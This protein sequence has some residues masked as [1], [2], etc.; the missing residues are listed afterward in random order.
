MKIKR[1]YKTELKPNRAQRRDLSN[2][3]GA[4]RFA[5]NWGLAR[6]TESYRLTGNPRVP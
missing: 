5:Y 1:A 4:A 6:K 3:A 2:H